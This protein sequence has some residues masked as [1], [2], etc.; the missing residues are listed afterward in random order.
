MIVE[1][2]W[3]TKGDHS[4]RVAKAGFNSN[5]GPAQK[6]GELLL[7]AREESGGSIRFFRVRFIPEGNEKGGGK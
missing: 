3:L 1:I 4:G 2:H 5:G 7:Q 6:L